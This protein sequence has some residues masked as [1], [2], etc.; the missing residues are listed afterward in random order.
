MHEEWAPNPFQMV[1]VSPAAVRAL[2][3]QDIHSCYLS[4]LQRLLEATIAL[5]RS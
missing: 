5:I 1:A 2:S 3:A 4:G